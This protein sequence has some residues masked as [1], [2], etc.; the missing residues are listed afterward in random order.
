MS[1]DSKKNKTAKLSSLFGAGKQKSLQPPL[2]YE[3]LVHPL[4][5]LPLCKKL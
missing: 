5:R 4:S 1:G 2:G 3:F